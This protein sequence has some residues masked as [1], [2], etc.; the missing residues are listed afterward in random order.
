MS[1]HLIRS[2]CSSL[3]TLLRSGRPGSVSTVTPQ[4]VHALLKRPVAPLVL[5]VRN[6]DE[7]LGERGHIPGAILC[8]LPQLGIK[9][10]ELKTHRSRS[11]VTV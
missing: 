6:P 8:P 4:H 9:L 11:I 3:R 1:R 7:F 5:D 2:F 10:D